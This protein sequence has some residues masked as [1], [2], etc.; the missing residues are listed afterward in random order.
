ME[1]EVLRLPLFADE[2]DD[3]VGIFDGLIQRFLIPYVNWDE[4]DL[5][6]VSRHFQLVNVKRVLAIGN[7]HLKSL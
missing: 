4:E 5:T 3:S 2:V 1:S 6:Q 7:D